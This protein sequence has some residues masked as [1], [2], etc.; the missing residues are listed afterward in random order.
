[1]NIISFI[2]QY[3]YLFSLLFF[4]LPVSIAFDWAV[5]FSVARKFATIK[6][7]LFIILTVL[8]WSAF[9]LFWI[10]KLGN[11]PSGRIIGHLGVV[12]IE[13]ILLFVLG[14]YNIASVFIWSKRKF[15]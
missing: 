15:T 9:D 6:A 10:D 2:H 3:A 12:P 13:E 1:M 5:N 7:A 4:I 11:F 8:F 14:F